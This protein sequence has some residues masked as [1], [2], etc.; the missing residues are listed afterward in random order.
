MTDI[1]FS[2]SLIESRPGFI[3][4]QVTG[5]NADKAFQYESGGHRW[6]RV[7]PTERKGR[8]HTSTI[9][10]AVLREPKATEVHIDNNKLE[11]TTCRG[12][13]PGGQH[14]NTCDSAVQ[15]KYGDIIVRCESERSQ[16]QNK[17]TAMSLLRAKILQEKESK[18]KAS[19]NSS[20]K[21]QIGTGQRGDKVR[22]I[23]VFDNQV[24]DHVTGRST[25]YN[26]Y[27]RGDLKELICER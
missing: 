4:L 19:F 6:Q 1:V 15:I 25:K 9:T 12:S 8:K 16:K 7:P 13:G 21:K 10:V 3:C 2:Y 26:K 23:R 27:E 17:E 20:R 22:T 11:I 24:K 14:R 18:S 5:K